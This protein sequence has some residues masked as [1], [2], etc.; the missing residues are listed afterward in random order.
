LALAPTWQP[1]GGLEGGALEFHGTDAVDLPAEILDGASDLTVS[2][3]FKTSGTSSNQTL[4]SS[5]GTAAAPEFAISIENGATIRIH[6]GGG[7]SVTWSYGRSLA[8]DRWHHL[9]AIRDTEAGQVSLYLDGGAFGSAQ[10]VSLQFL[11][12]STLALGQRHQSTAT[13]D[14]AYAYSGRLD[15]V[16]IHSAVLEGKY[17]SELFRP[18]DLD[19]DG[20]PDDYETALT[21]NLITLVGGDADS[22]GDG[23]TNRQEFE[24]GSDPTDYYNGQAPTIILLS[25]SGQTVYN[26]ERTPLSLVFLV[27]DG[28]NPLVGAPVSLSQL[29]LIGSLETLDGETLATALPLKTDSE[30]KVAVHFKAN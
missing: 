6:T 7:Q 8:D 27:T 1:T 12:V 17:F 25:G 16:R 23:L 14:S 3:W 21:G 22:D 5:A 18:N 10:S 29:E 28:A 26:G 15:G 24:N 4:L 20:L 13:F 11:A 19:Q 30:G 2:L 9:I